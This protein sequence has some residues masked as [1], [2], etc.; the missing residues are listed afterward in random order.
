MG[1]KTDKMKND[2][3]YFAIALF[4][5]SLFEWITTH[6]PNPAPGNAVETASLFCLIYL[7][8]KKIE[9]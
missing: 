3:L 7:C 4:L 2:Y 6:G 5:S 9:E 1:S 8:L